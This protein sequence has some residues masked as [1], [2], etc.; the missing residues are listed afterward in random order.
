MPRMMTAH[1]IAQVARCRTNENVAA[2]G[3]NDWVAEWFAHD[4]AALRNLY[5]R[6]PDSPRWLQDSRARPNA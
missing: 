3:Y 2:Q 5:A 6:L 1:L 4:V